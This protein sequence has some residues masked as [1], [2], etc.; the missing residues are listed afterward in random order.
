MLEIKLEKQL[1]IVTI[2]FAE[3][4]TSIQQAMEK[5]NGLVV[6]EEELPGCKAT[7][8]QLAG[9]RN[10]LDTYRKDVKK[11]M[12]KPITDF[13]NQCKELIGLVTDAET[14]IKKGIEVFNEKIRD[15]NRVN[16][17]V[18]INEAIEEQQLNAKYATQLTVLDKYT[19]LSAKAK[20]TK[21]D[22]SQRAFIL[23]QEQEREIEQIKIEKERVA[24]ALR[25]ENERIA[26]LKALEEKRQI[27]LAAAEVKRKKE[28][29]ESEILR[30]AENLQIAINT[31]EQ[32]NTQ[33]KQKISLDD[34]VALI[35]SGATAMTII[36]EIN[37]KK[38]RIILL[39]KP[40]IE[41]TMTTPVVVEIPKE[42]P[43]KLPFTDLELSPTPT[44]SIKMYFIEMRVEA[45]LED[46]KALSQ[47]L[48]DNNY[49]Y[50]TIN[51]GAL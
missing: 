47:F 37:K 35:D 32:A 8:K 36:Q 18:T 17:I 9:Y 41:T 33:I 43:I 10:K 29:E 22:I 38:H 21:T 25:L 49:N 19:Q 30:I 31:I 27:E 39:E 16:A 48:K 23:L 15:T 46:I 1:P 14:P 3:V 44:E 34:Y 20:E 11:E 51:K 7:Q 5:Y 42:E 40:V 24:E 12:T 13:E 45:N 6:T 4:K 28:F 2:N 26:E 50:E